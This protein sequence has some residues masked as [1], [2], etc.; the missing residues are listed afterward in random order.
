MAHAAITELEAHTRNAPDHN[1]G[2]VGAER[3]VGNDDL[4]R[5]EPAPDGSP[6]DRPQA[7]RGVVGSR[8]RP[9]VGSAPSY[10]KLL[11]RGHLYGGHEKRAS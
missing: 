7:C 6:T 5:R 1:P 3:R 8:G 11:G 10:P 9:R 2:T 4:S